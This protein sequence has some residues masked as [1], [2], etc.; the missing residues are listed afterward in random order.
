MAASQLL[1]LANENAE[2]AGRSGV[3]SRLVSLKARN[4]GH[5]FFYG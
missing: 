1:F 4:L 2:L 3:L 5:G